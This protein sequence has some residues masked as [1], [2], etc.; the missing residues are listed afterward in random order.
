MALTYSNKRFGVEDN[1]KWVEVDVTF[2]DSYPTGGETVTPADIGLRNI[3]AVHRVFSVYPDGATSSA[4]DTDAYDVKP[5]IT[6]TSV[7]LAAYYNGAQVSSLADI[8]L[9]VK[10]FRFI[11]SS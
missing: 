11:G 1:H 6:T 3:I 5:V 8:H 7:K 10:R 2:D 9:V 4:T